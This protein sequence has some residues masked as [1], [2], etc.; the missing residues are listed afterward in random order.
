MRNWIY[1]ESSSPAALLWYSRT[2]QR[3][4]FFQDFSADFKAISQHPPA[5]L[6]LPRSS[7]SFVWSANFIVDKHQTQTRK[8]CI[9]LT[10][11]KLPDR[12]WFRPH[13]SPQLTVIL[14]IWGVQNEQKWRQKGPLRCSRVTYHHIRQGAPRRQHTLRPILSGTRQMV[15]I[16]GPGEIRK[17]DPHSFSGFGDLSADKG[18]WNGSVWRRRLPCGK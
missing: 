17:L 9:C 12:L 16:K 4:R 3:S 15:G 11:P 14:K 8:F 10:S 7:P 6:S 13:P 1:K 5:S 2:C 18:M